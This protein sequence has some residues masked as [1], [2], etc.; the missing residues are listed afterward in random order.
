M[1]AVGRLAG[2]IAHDFNNILTGILGNV[3]YILTDLT[4]VCEYFEA[5]KEIEESALMATDIVEKL[6]GFSRKSLMKSTVVNINDIIN[7]AYRIVERTIDPR[8]IIRTSLDHNLWPAAADKT[9]IIQILINLCLN[10][11][12]AMAEGGA[13]T[14]KTENITI[15]ENGLRNQ[16]S[17]VRA[18]EFVRISVADTGCG[19]PSEVQEQIFEPFF[20][21]KKAG[22]GTGLGLAMVYGI[23]KQLEGWINCHSEIGHGT[24]FTIHLPRAIFSVLQVSPDNFP[25]RKAPLSADKTVLVVEDNTIVKNFIKRILAR[26]GF[27][28]IMAGDGEE[29]VDLYR[30]GWENID[31]VLLDM[32]IPKLNGRDALI[33]MKKINPSI[34]ALLTSGYLFSDNEEPLLSEYQFLHK[35]FTENDLLRQIEKLL[36]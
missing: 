17:Y 2:G 6:L 1:E 13:I 5:L 35:P 31:L 23:V 33:N 24:T 21:T 18:G 16:P 12:D 14:I 34:K 9:L 11:Q 30:R 36:Y 32:T 4:P 29:A 26:N 27:K 22:H 15:D 10:A 19:M 3:S 8:I 20:T 25:D 7:E 28:V